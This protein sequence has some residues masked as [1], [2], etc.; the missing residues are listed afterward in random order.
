MNITANQLAEAIQGADLDPEDI[1]IDYSGRGMYGSTCIGIK[2]GSYSSIARFI[3]F[4]SK[5]LA[6]SESD[7]EDELNVYELT[8]KFHEVSDLSVQQDSLGHGAVMYFPSL[9]LEE[10]EIKV[11]KSMF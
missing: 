3:F 5:S 9:S 11:Y 1:M 10:A 4:L 2:T 7:G 8:D 6:E